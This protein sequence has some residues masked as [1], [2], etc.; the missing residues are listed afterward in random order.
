MKSTIKDGKTYVND[1][2]N[3]LLEV[4]YGLSGEVVFA[5][6]RHFQSTSIFCG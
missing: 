4:R 3:G 1:P 6:M 5:K 2:K